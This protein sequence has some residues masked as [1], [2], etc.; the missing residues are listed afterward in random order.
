MEE[1]LRK[2]LRKYESQQTAATS[3]ED[4]Q[5]FLSAA[6]EALEGDQSHLLKSVVQDDKN[7]AFI[8]SV[9]WDLLSVIGTYL[10]ENNDQAEANINC[11]TVIEKIAEV[12]KTKEVF[13]GL[14][15]QLDQFL[16]SAVSRLF[17]HPLQTVLRKFGSSKSLY[18]DQALDQL[19]A[20]IEAIPL[21]QYD[22][23]DRKQKRLL[24]QDED[25]QQLEETC[26]DLVE[27]VAPF[28]FE[29]Q[30]TVGRVEEEDL[31][32]RKG[33]REALSA[34]KEIQRFLIRLL[35]YP[36]VFVEV[37]FDAT[38]DPTGGEEK[39]P[40]R[41]A[42]ESGFCT[43]CKQILTYL[44]DMRCS[45]TS[46]LSHIPDTPE[47][48]EAA[49]TA[50]ADEVQDEQRHL[51]MLGLSN[52]VYL[53]HTV[54]LQEARRPSVYS[55]DY[56]FALHKIHVAT[57]LQK[58]EEPT[59]SKGMELLL[60]LTNQVEELALS[61]QL[62]MEDIYMN[63]PKTLI[64]IMVTHTSETLR[65]RAVHILPIYIDK[66]DWKGRY[67][68]LTV[69]LESSEHSGVKG[70]LIGRIKEYVHATLQ[71]VSWFL[72]LLLDVALQNHF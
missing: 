16:D 31:Q 18:L 45:I 51:S 43:C 38:S 42:Y 7:Q 5:A 39:E 44:T 71:S 26:V 12:G 1:Q 53:V 13:I 67:R 30:E 57:L 27:F 25:Y 32:S 69:L 40:S 8:F 15:E 28:V 19:H 2:C 17:F 6:K 47:P 70:F 3:T 48:K 37:D 52:L 34:R 14:L 65:K 58:T 55:P 59:L 56:L 4:S 21:P 62:L 41:L 23:L 64:R 49:A 68:L 66:F 60:T 29:I 46:L 61:S 10:S 35:E 50:E 11:S 63:I 24:I 72:S 33:F 54:R 20:C 22:G 9:G 36:L